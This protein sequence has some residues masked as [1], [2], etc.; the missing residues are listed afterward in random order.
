MFTGLVE[1]VG[2]IHTIDGDANGARLAIAART[3]VEG[4]A[5]GDSVSVDGACLTAVTVSSD[6]FAVD[7]VAETLRRTA[8]GTRQAGHAVNLER[9]VRVGDR[10]GG[11]LVQGHVDGTGTV[12]SVRSDGAST[13]L[14][15]T[16]PADILRYVVEK[17]SITIDGVS[18][19]VAAR[20][21]GGFAVAL[22]PHTLGQT[23]LGEL[24]D[25]RIVNL[26]V[27]MVAKYVEA[28]VAPY[29]PG[30]EGP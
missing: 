22:I 16:A 20:H 3:V 25:G 14:T 11:H 2:T 29:R 28:L 21:D 12:S 10:L 19:T 8:L 27:D 7:V 4:L 26:E 15:L 17:G 13:Y 30:R 23:T 5:V 24:V 1:E 6:G 18:L 9:A